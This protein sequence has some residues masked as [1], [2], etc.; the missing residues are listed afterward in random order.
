MDVTTELCASKEMY[1][2]LQRKFL[3]KLNQH[4][5][6][7]ETIAATQ[8]GTGVAFIDAGCKML[9]LMQTSE[10][11]AVMKAMEISLEN[12]SHWTTLEKLEVYKKR[13]CEMGS[14]P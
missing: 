14:K 5:V 3:D 10:E 1:C 6:Y 8:R 13:L 7:S 2:E 12:E 9:R 11:P 4:R